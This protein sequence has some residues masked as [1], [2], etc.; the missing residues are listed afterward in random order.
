MYALVDTKRF[1]WSITTTPIP[2]F[3]ARFSTNADGTNGA[4]I[5]YT[6][7]EI[8]T[9]T[10]THARD[11]HNH[12]T[13]T[14]VCRAVFDSLDAHIGDEFKSP[15]A[16]APS[17]TGWNSTM[18]PK[19]MF[20]Q[21]MLTY[22]KRTPDAVRQNKMTFY[23][24]FNPKDPPEVLF[25][26][27]SDCQEVAIIAKVPFTTK[28]LLMNAVDLFTCSGLCTQDMDDWEQKLA[29]DQTYFNL[30][31]FIQATYQHRITSDTVT[32]SASG[33]STDRRS[34]CRA[35]NR[36]QCIRRRNR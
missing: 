15:P 4:E 7:E 24:A 18:L 2:E 21:L 8:L 36:R 12:D 11:K 30:R 14:N 29:A 34:V 10:A 19:D 20:D 27:F 33:Y 28:Q 6:R 3:P 26:H 1:T 35:I 23:S 25:K 16:S 9:I 22:G 32:A 17:K 13:G 5:P 31:P